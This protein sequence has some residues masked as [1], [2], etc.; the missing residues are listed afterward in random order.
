M[1]P[2]R[3]LV[4]EDSKPDALLLLSQLRHEGCEQQSQ[5]GARAASLM[6][7]LAARKWDVELKREFNVLPADVGLRPKNHAENEMVHP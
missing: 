6:A 5:R 3:V 1:K 2:L 7:A 4:I